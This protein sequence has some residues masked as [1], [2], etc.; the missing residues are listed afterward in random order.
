MSAGKFCHLNNRRAGG[1]EPLPGDWR[2]GRTP[3]SPAPSARDSFSGWTGLC[4]EAAARR[5]VVVWP[6]ATT[7]PFMG[8]LQL[9]RVSAQGLSAGASCSWEWAGQGSNL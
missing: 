9:A 4:S 8:E 6:Q 3:A 5:R 7:L 2:M 1:I